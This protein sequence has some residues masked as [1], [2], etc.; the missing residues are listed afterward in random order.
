MPCA[1]GR[2]PQGVDLQIGPILPER[3]PIARSAVPFGLV[4]PGLA[5][6]GSSCRWKSAADNSDGYYVL[7]EVLRFDHTACEAACAQAYDSCLGYE[8]RSYT[9]RC[10]LWCVVR[11]SI[12]GCRP[13]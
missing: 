1:G 11:E 5:A 7:T 2:R 10:E 3:I 12:L 13:L 9:G 8:Y 4:D 6:T